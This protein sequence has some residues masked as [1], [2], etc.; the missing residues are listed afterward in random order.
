MYELAYN[1][2]NGPVTVDADGRVIGGGEFGAA[3]PSDPVT[4]VAVAGGLTMVTDKPEDGPAAD[5][6]R[7]IERLNARLGE[8]LAQ[9]Q[10]ALLRQANALGLQTTDRSKE[11]LA[12]S[13]AHHAVVEVA[14]EPVDAPGRNTQTDDVTTEPDVTA[15]PAAPKRRKE[16]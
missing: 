2:T 5:A 3:D 13:L 11:T 10:P 8:Y 9:D 16:A 4:V 7:R 1:S 15:E 6:A 14:A 12:R